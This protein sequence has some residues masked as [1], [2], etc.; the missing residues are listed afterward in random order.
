[1][2]DLL[3]YTYLLD[4]ENIENEIVRLWERYQKILNKKKLSW[5]ELNEARAILY[6]L[7]YLYPEK[8]AIESLESRIKIIRPKIS[9][10]KFFLAIDGNNKEILK[11]YKDNEKFNKLKK[12][13]LIVKNIKNKVKN[14]SYLDEQ[15]FNEIYSKLEQ[16]LYPSGDNF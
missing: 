12:F 11:K 3:K 4:I 13:Y 16:K 6:F 9:L 8:I 14:N 10:D 1:M 15:R 5:E 2:K 7:G